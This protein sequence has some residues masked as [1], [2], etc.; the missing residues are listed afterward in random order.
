MKRLAAVAATLILAASPALAQG[1]SADKARIEATVDKAYPRLEAIYKDLHRNPETAFQETRSAALL[2]REMRKLGFEVTEKV[3][4]T[5]VVAVLRNGEGPTVMVRTDLDA[6]PMEEKTGLPYA[7]R[8]KQV[9]N[10]AET[11]VDHSCGHDMH[12]AWWLGA[13]EAL[14][15][16]KDRWRGT[17]VFIGQPAEETLAGAKAMLDDG[18]YTRFPKPDYAFAAHV[19]PD[20]AGAVMIKDGVASSA[21]DAL[22]LTFHG[23]GAH[24]STPHRSIDPVVMGAHFVSDVQ[25]VVSRETDPQGFAVVTVGAFQ[26][27][28]VGNIIPDQAELRLSLRSLDPAVREKLN[29]GVQRTAKAVADMAGAPEPTL[30]RLGGTAAMR[31]DGALI[32]RMS[33]VVREVFGSQARFV[34]ANAPGFSASEDFA[35]FMEQ[36]TPSLYYFVGGMDPAVLEELKR[37]GKPVPGNH[38]PQFAPTPGPTIRA[39]ALLL[40]VS[41]LTVAPAP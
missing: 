16:M 18:L 37:A 3:G 40:A 5:G 35:Y 33:P 24:G 27:G 34:P 1:L 10:G 32:Q 11:F 31:N 21:S 17:V 41:V 22:K 9:V 28:T 19:S 8:A 6:L 15:K 26:A 29:A 23:R 30:E 36:D 13:A 2:A 25:T 39:G 7:S 20:A 12:M 14:V 38:S 4:K